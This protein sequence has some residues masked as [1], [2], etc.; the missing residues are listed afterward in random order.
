MILKILYTAIRLSLAVLFAYSAFAKSAGFAMFELRIIETTPLGWHWSALV[1]FGFIFLEFFLAGYFLVI[2]WKNKSI[3][4]LTYFLLLL[5]TV[6]LAQLWYLRGND[7]NCG[8]MG[9]ALPFSPLEAILKNLVTGFLL[10]LLQQFHRHTH[11]VWRYPVIGSTVVAVLALATAYFSMAEGTFLKRN[12][13]LDQKIR[14]RSEL[15]RAV[16]SRV[17]FNFEQ[18]GCL[19]VMLSQSC[20]YCQMAATRL[21]E[22]QAGFSGIPVFLIINGDSAENDV[23]M[24]KYGIAAY[25]YLMLRAEPFLKLS[26]THLPAIYIVQKG[27]IR[28]TLTLNSLDPVFIERLLREK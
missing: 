7:I 12:T 13:V 25:P 18:E 23:F 24:E 5:F 8:C 11:F 20:K 27:I 2:P 17:Q 22:M 1:G 6:Y 28:K 9:E 21:G 26:G 19:I 14:F 16:D 3:E 4:R 10:F 15:I